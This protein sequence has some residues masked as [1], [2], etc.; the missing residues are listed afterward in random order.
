M[1]QS[2]LLLN[3][4]SYLFIKRSVMFSLF[5]IGALSYQSMRGGRHFNYKH[6]EN[7]AFIEDSKPPKRPS[8]PPKLKKGLVKPSI[9]TLNEALLIDFSDDTSSIS[10]VSSIRT[11]PDNQV[12][13]LLDKSVTTYSQLPPPIGQN[14][15]EDDPFEVKL[16]YGGAPLTPTKQS[17]GS[18][19]SARPCYDSEALASESYQDAS[20]V[21]SSN[22]PSPTHSEP[23]VFSPP[24]CPPRT[25]ANLPCDIEKPKKKLPALPSVAPVG[26]KRWGSKDGSDNFNTGSESSVSSDKA[27]NPSSS[28]M[29][30][31]PVMEI[32]SS[33]RRYNN[34]NSSSPIMSRNSST[35]STNNQ[36]DK[37][38]DWINVAMDDLNINTSPTHSSP[39]TLLEHSKLAPSVSSS[40]QYSNLT[41]TGVRPKE[42]KNSPQKTRSLT[43]TIQVSD[44]NPPAIPP[45]QQV[46]MADHGGDHL[47]RIHPIIK[48]GKQ[49][50]KTHY[51]LLMPRP[52]SGTSNTATVKPMNISSDKSHYRNISEIN[53]GLNMAT[54]LE[55][56]QMS[57]QATAS[58]AVYS[59]TEDIEWND[60]NQTN[61]AISASS[62]SSKI[63]Q[64][65]ELV[66]GVTQQECQT[67]LANN[68]WDVD[69]AIKYLKVE[70][71]FGLGI[72][73]HERCRQL[74]DTSNWDLQSAA[75]VLLKEYSTGSAV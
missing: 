46:P 7:D 43:P 16:S 33:P 67:V 56:E 36:N 72:A 60:S 21:F 58:A 66:H 23:P 49:V 6:F 35:S 18:N 29:S 9:K 5:L 44:V 51:F 54:N 48:D 26:H 40:V 59:N 22:L 13:S 73:T 38:F 12:E 50:S 45:R 17:L 24:P 19:T 68:N 69:T 8:S 31:L 2:I 28:S 14:F 53:P 30:S 71:L 47:P 65:Q 15:E 55:K 41:S 10:S 34:I 3:K 61:E 1:R 25:Y 64:V 32:S 75:D 57:N 4:L 37:V 11:A 62:A 74:L 63:Q 39:K 20:D 27:L 70:Q 42:Y 52:K